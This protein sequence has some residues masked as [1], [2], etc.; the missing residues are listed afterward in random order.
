MRCAADT[1]VC[2]FKP[3]S[4]AQFSSYGGENPDSTVTTRF[5]PAAT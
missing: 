3:R 4:F 2:L 1:D 5:S